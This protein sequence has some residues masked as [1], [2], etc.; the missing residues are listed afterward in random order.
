MDY[1]MN[2]QPN[3]Y[4]TLEKVLL[5]FSLFL[6][7]ML[8]IS[9][10]SRKETITEKQVFVFDTLNNKKLK[11]YELMADSLKTENKTLQNKVSTQTTKINE[12]ANRKRKND[13]L[14][15]Y[16]TDAE[17]FRIFSKFDSI[18]NQRGK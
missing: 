8:I 16:A 4:T 9:K 13:T 11:R 18:Y 10:E 14:I 5:V 2:N 3:N 15:K 6:L 7:T 17:L 12:I 1:K